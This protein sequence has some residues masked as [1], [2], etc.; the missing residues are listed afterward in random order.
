LVT[1]SALLAHLTAALA[2]PLPGPDAQARMAPQPRGGW[3]DGYRPEHL[4]HAAGLILLFPID[5]QPHLV[6]T[7]RSSRVRHAG[8]ISLPGGVIEPGESPEQAAVRE[9]REEVDCPSDK[10]RVLGRLTPVDIP[11]SAFR[12]HPIVAVT[13]ARPVLTASDDEVARILEL[14]L[15]ALLAPAAR[16]NRPMQR[17]ALTLDVPVFE[18]DGVTI[19]GATA[20]VLAELLALIGWAE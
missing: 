17:G 7:V 5:D 19:W 10:V 2:G 8:Q 9:A 16:S 6:L 13:D 15:D 3:P 4:R 12:L 11:V 18:I 1:Y 20:M 14:P